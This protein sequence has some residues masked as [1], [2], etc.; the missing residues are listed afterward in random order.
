MFLLP[1]TQGGHGQRNQAKELGKTR[2]DVH[3]QQQRTVMMNGTYD[4]QVGR[5]QK[6]D[7]VIGGWRVARKRPVFRVS[8]WFVLSG[9]LYKAG[10]QCQVLGINIRFF[11]P[12]TLNRIVVAY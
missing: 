10:P 12:G 4:V 2:A 6:L 5:G 9:L 7:R 11:T 8:L 3:N 1:D